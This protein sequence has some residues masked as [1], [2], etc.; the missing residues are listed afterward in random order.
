VD[1]V[2]TEY[3]ISEILVGGEQD[4]IRFSAFMKDGFV[5][6]SGKSIQQRRGRN[7]IGSAMQLASSYNARCSWRSALVLTAPF[8]Q[9]S[10]VILSISALL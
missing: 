6:D 8:Q 4:S 5:V 9:A 10:S 7:A 1:N 3:E 2:L